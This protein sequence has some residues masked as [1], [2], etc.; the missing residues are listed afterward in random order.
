MKSDKSY[1]L[2]IKQ[3]KLPKNISQYYEGIKK[4]I[5]IKTNTIFLNFER[6][7]L[8]HPQRL[9]LNFTDKIDLRRKDK[10][11]ALSNLDI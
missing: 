7:R 5:N 6:S 2:C 3:K 8:S 1:I 4:G 9:L 10:Y 11:I